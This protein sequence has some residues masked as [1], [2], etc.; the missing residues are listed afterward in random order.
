MLFPPLALVVASDGGRRRCFRMLCG[1][2]SKRRSMSVGAPLCRAFGWPFQG[3]SPLLLF[4]SA[5]AGVSTCGHTTS[6]AEEWVR[7]VPAHTCTLVG[8]LKLH[9][10]SDLMVRALRPHGAHAST[11]ATGSAR[12]KCQARQ[13]REGRSVAARAVWFC[14]IGV[15]PSLRDPVLCA[16]S[17]WCAA[18]V[19]LHADGLSVPLPMPRRL[20]SDVSS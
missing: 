20:V 18:C 16:C 13:R 8:E 15:V 2:A 12:Q 5:F 19:W 9:A 7:C 10:P 11:E 3:H 17:W 4:P 14:S 1:C 6:C